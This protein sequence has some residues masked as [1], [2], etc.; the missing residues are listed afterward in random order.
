MG[1]TLLIM[2]VRDEHLPE[3]RRVLGAQEEA[4]VWDPPEEPHTPGWLQDRPQVIAHREQVRGSLQRFLNASLSKLDLRLTTGAW[5]LRRARARVG[6][7]G[8]GRSIGP[9]GS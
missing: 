5:V 2:V 8:R 7:L 6:R 4:R 3:V 9:V 1:S